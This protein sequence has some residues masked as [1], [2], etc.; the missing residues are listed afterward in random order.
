MVDVDTI[1]SWRLVYWL[2][3]FFFTYLKVKTV[4]GYPGC[5]NG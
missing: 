4:S 1:A 5:Q 3:S 2:K